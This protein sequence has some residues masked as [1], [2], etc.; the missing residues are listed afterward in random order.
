M[1]ERDPEWAGWCA[2]LVNLNDLSA[3]GAVPVGMLDSV[4]A[5]N[6]SIL[7]KVIRGLSRAAEAW[8]AYRYWAATPS[9]VFPRRCR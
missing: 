2:A 4:G 3:M 5:P 7:S 1:V 6:T 8:G 9:S